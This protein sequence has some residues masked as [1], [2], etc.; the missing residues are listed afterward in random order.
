[1]LSVKK[2]HVFHNLN[3]IKISLEIML[4]D[5]AEKKETFF[6]LKKHNFLTK[7]SLKHRTFPKGIT[8][9]FGQKMPIFWLFRFG[10]NV[11]SALFAI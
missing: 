3:L 7:K 4:S 9:A 5:F 2:C 1:M 11:V 10:Q 8:H 6:D